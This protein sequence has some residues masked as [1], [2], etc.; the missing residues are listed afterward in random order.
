M[1]SKNCVQSCYTQELPTQRYNNARSAL[2]IAILPLDFKGTTLQQLRYFIKAA[3][4]LRDACHDKSAPERPLDILLWLRRR[5]NKEA[6]KAG[7]SQLYRA[8]CLREASKIEKEISHTC[9]QLSQ[10]KL[11]ILE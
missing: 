9:T 11:S 10:G 4:V 6:R 8:Q 1:D 2:A 7:K 5:L 3:Q